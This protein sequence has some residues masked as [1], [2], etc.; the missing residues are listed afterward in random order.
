MAFSLSRW[1]PR[2]LFLAWAVYWLVLL[3]T[4]MRPALTILL[5]ALNAPPGQA[6]INVSM[7]NGVVSLVSKAAGASYSGSAS[8]MT[9]ALWIAGPPLVLWAIWAATRSHPLAAR[10]RIS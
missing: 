8:L 6:S 2:H 5:R 9:I 7:A 3:A 10:E 4:V 1:R